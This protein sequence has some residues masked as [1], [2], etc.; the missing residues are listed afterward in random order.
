MR[1]SDGSIP[2]IRFAGAMAT[3]SVSWNTLAGLRFSTMVPIFRSGTSGQI[4]VSSSGSY[5]NLSMSSGLITCR[6][7]SHFG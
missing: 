2:G 7:R 5:S 3:C 4:L 1:S 6:Y